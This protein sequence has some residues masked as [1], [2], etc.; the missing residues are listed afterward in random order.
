MI[1][2]TRTRGHEITAFVRSPQKLTPSRSLTVVQG[3]PLRSE[4]ITGGD[5]H[6]TGIRNVRQ[7]YSCH[8]VRR[9]M[10][11]GMG[12]EFVAMGYEERGILVRHLKGLAH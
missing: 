2:L 5:V 3:D 9:S 6:K 8:C 4:T 7:K 10:S 11:G 1:D 12:V